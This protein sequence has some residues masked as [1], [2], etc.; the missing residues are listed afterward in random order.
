MATAKGISSSV[1]PQGG[2]SG[3]SKRQEDIIQEGLNL[4]GPKGLGNNNQKPYNGQV[5]HSHITS[6]NIIAKSKDLSKFPI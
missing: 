6:Q 3:K 1:P 4:S 5:P 2:S